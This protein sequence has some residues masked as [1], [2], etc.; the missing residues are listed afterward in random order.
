MLN[1]LQNRK[2]LFILLLIAFAS[3]CVRLLITLDFQDSA[4]LYVS[5]PF[6]LSLLIAATYKKKERHKRTIHGRFWHA[7]VY[8]MIVMLGSSIVLYEGFVCVLMFMPIYFIGMFI[9]YVVT[10][11]ME[12]HRQ[13]SNSRSK[14]FMISILP[15]LILI[16]GLEGTHE[17][18]S[19]NRE[20][21][22]YHSQILPMSVADIQANLAQPNLAA[23]LANNAN[24]ERSWLLAIFPL[25]HTIEAGSL[26][27]GDIHRIHYR[28]KRWFFT[29]VHEGRTDLELVEVNEQRIRTRFIHDDSYLSHYLHLH[30]TQIDFQ[31]LPAQQ[32]PAGNT[33]QTKV[34]LRIAFTRKLDPAWYFEPLQRYAVRQMAKHLITT[35]MAEPPTK[36]A[37]TTTS[38]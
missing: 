30:G 13:R 36:V 5:I 37:L 19:F 20:N 38:D 6:G 12:K 18:L 7:L 17:S 2:T 1:K 22:V 35:L 16:T 29:N 26:Q 32:G 4:L 34:T 10:V 23:N 31:P 27:A 11:L 9:A 33:P 14:S 21:V 15:T 25:P 28:Y 3:L 24:T 8:S